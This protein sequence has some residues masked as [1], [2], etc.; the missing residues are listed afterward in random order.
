M[1]RNTREKFDE[2]KRGDA[3]DGFFIFVDIFRRK[4]QIPSP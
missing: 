2:R 4:F 1:A 3:D